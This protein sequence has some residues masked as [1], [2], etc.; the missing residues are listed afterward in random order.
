MLTAVSMLPKHDFTVALNGSGTFADLSGDMNFSYLSG[1]SADFK[2][3]EKD[4]LGL[5]DKT[6][7]L[8]AEL[9]LTY[10]PE[11]GIDPTGSELEALASTFADIKPGEITVTIT[12]P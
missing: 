7:E 9:S 10:R 2:K 11:S 6:T 12:G 1:A 3:V 4:V 5:F 8:Y